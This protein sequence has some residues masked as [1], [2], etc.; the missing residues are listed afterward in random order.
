MKTFYAWR[1]N[2]LLYIGGG[3]GGGG[4]YCKQITTCSELFSQHI[5]VCTLCLSMVVTTHFQLQRRLFQFTN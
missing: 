1:G 4:D 5:V 2:D 3:G